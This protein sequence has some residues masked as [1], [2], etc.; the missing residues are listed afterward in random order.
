M[1]PPV[2][3]DEPAGLGLRYLGGPT[4]LLEVGGLRLLTDPSFD[5]PGD[6]PV[7]S[8]ASALHTRP[9]T[10]AHTPTTVAAEAAVPVRIS[11]S[12]SPKSSP[13]RPG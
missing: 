9:V 7:G 3:S 4:A 1:A 10:T 13:H 6:Y 5:P 11:H 12:P 8:D 2:T